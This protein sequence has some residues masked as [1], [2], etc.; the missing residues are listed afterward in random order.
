MPPKP[1]QGGFR[2]GNG[3]PGGSRPARGSAAQRF[4]RSHSASAARRRRVGRTSNAQVFNSRS[5]LLDPRLGRSR[6]EVALVKASTAAMSFANWKGPPLHHLLAFCKFF[7]QISQ[8]WILKRH[9][10]TLLSR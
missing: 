9:A 7:P 6:R 10:P 1:R 4:Q 8:C 3:A 5:G 2:G